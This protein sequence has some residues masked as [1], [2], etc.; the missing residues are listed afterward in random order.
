MAAYAE[1]FSLAQK[2]E[3]L[4]QRPEEDDEEEIIP[5][6]VSASLALEL[7][8]RLDDD[9]KLDTMLMQQKTSG[10]LLSNEAKSACHDLAQTA[11]ILNLSHVSFA[12]IVE[13]L[14]ALQSIDRLSARVTHD[15]KEDTKK[16]NI[17]AE[18]ITGHLQNLNSVLVDKTNSVDITTMED[19][20]QPSEQASATMKKTQK[21]LDEI[22]K[23][24]N[25]LQAAG[26]FALC[27]SETANE[28]TSPL[29][30]GPLPHASLKALADRIDTDHK[31]CRDVQRDLNVKY[32][33]PET[34]F[35]QT[36]IEQEIERLRLEC[37]QLE[38]Q[39][40]DTINSGT[41][42]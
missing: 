23:L 10:I 7:H 4:L 14:L 21:Y 9:V 18:L 12:N 13:T 11:S 1:L 24:R 32:G 38:E 15:L 17:V 8:S 42:G 35:D 33:Y 5:R 40:N 36:E 22:Q 34:S 26:V 39:L 31:K 20:K 25:E 27:P 37:S 6:H 29:G 16:A 41:E 30:V 28:F 3:P 2:Y 19:E